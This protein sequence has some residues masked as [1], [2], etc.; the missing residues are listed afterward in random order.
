MGSVCWGQVQ[1]LGLPLVVLDL[2]PIPKT[3]TGGKWLVGLVLGGLAAKLVL[4]LVAKSKNRS[5]RS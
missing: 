1:F 4:Y 2:H 3:S 5:F